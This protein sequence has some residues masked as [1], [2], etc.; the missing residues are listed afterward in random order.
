MELNEAIE[1]Y[2]SGYAGLTALVGKR[3]YPIKLPDNV[4]QSSVVY[5]LISE[6]EVES[7]HQPDTDLLGAIYSFTAWAESLSAAN[8]VGRQIRAAFK[9]YSGVMGGAGGVTIGAILKISRYSGI[10]LIQEGAKPKY[11]NVQDFEIWYYM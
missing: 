8:S 4:T 5:Q 3:I 1:T 10:D 6:E 7:F 9:N 11:K 2:L